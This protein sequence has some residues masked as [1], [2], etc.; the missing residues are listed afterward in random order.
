MGADRM[1]DVP[2]RKGLP[3]LA[4]LGSVEQPRFK[5]KD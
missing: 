5:T 3:H 2:K 4:R 1:E